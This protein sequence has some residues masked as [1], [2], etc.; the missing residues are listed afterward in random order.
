[1]CR[2]QGAIGE[3]ASDMDDDYKVAFRDSFTRKLHIVD[4]DELT[5]YKGMSC[6]F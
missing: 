3:V 4:F 6:D 2:W 1:M 5:P